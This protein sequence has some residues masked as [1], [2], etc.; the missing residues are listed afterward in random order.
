ME[1]AKEI[2]QYTPQLYRKNG[3]TEPVNIEPWASGIFLKVDGI[4]F[5]LTAGHVLSENGNDINPEDVGIMI[6]NIYHILNGHVK[7]TDTNVDSTNSK[8]DLTIWKLEDERVVND[9]LMKYKFLEPD[10]IDIDHLPTIK[11]NY[12][13]V[14]FP[15]TRTKLKPS[16]H[17][18][19]VDPF[20]F[21][22]KQMKGN[23]YTKL[24][25]ETHSNIILEYRKR[26][27]RNFNGTAGQG[28]DPYGLSGCGLWHLPEL[29]IDLD[30]KVPHKLVGIMT[31]WHSAHNAV[32]ATR[33]HIVTEVIRKEF[34]LSLPKSNITEIKLH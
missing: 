6:G 32:V 20:M 19:K 4:H 26:K 1:A 17:S 9:L 10:A 25:F 3:S 21:L 16:T 13:I 5:L 28:P 22:T 8:I 31:E 7:Y 27:I 29:K 33:I 18:I 11:P 24:A 2:L 14:G 23:V 12:L 30:G 15:I 34:G